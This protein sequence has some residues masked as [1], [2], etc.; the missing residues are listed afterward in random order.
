MGWELL[1]RFSFVTHSKM[2]LEYCIKCICIASAFPFLILCVFPFCR[3]LT[4]LKSNIMSNST[5]ILHVTDILNPSVCSYNM[6]RCWNCKRSRF[7]K[8]SGHVTLVKR[9]KL[10]KSRENMKWHYDIY[11][12]AYEDSTPSFSRPLHLDSKLFIHLK[13]QHYPNFDLFSSIVMACQ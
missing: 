6:S 7:Y 3:M 12:K 9:L 8:H 2:I 10:Q 5:L 11:N 4:K 13:F 1:F